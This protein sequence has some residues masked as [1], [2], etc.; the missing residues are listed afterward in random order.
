M[1]AGG[2]LVNAEDNLAVTVGGVT[3]N[4][5]G[6]SGTS[7]GWVAGAGFDVAL[8][9]NLSARLEY[10][11]IRADGLR[12]TGPIPGI[13]GMGTASESGGYRDNILRVGL[14]YRFGPRGGPGVLEPTVSPTAYAINYDFLP[15]LVLADKAKPA[16]Q[17]QT[18]S[19]PIVTADAAPGSASIALPSSSAKS[20]DKAKP[21]KQVQTM[22][23][24][25]VTADAAPETSSIAL[26]SSSAKSGFKNFNEIGALEDT[27]T[28]ALPKSSSKKR[29]EREEDESQRLKRIMA[30][31]AGC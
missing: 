23:P 29:R 14:N 26:P 9:S 18:M 16:K 6:L 28:I 1:T 22:S 8:S 20:A 25:I 3:G 13:L 4:F 19:A 7:L 15:S 24:P 21:A 27:D 17:V 2:A 10:L 31:C 30:I 11:H 12:L 5:Q